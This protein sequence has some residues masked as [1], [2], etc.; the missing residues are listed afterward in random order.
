MKVGPE[1][2][3]H[4]VPANGAKT[5]NNERGKKEYFF[6]SVFSLSFPAGT[7]GEGNQTGPQSEKQIFVTENMIRLRRRFN[8]ATRP[9]PKALAI[10]H[11]ETHLVLYPGVIKIDDKS[12]TNSDSS[13]LEENRFDENIQTQE[14][15]KQVEIQSQDTVSFVRIKNFH[16]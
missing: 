5:H 3:G 1:M 14:N 16:F 6:S 10:V 8:F 12:K 15:T 4:G 7:S 2:E 13:A 11:P 9:R